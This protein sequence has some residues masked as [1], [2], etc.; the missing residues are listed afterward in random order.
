MSDNCKTQLCIA[1]FLFIYSSKYDYVSQILC[2]STVALIIVVQQRWLGC[3]ISSQP[4]NAWREAAAGSTDSSAARPSQLVDCVGVTQMCFSS[5]WAL[6]QHH[7]K[8]WKMARHGCCRAPPRVQRRR[9]V[10]GGLK[11][12]KERERA[13]P[14]GVGNDSK[15]NCFASPGFSVLFWV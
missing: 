2:G 6:N 13:H 14:P 3:L 7:W 15:R 12:G 11:R 1:C 8:P 10:Q 9:I 5:M 4:P